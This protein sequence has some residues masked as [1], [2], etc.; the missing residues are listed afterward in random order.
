MRSCSSRE[1]I[2]NVQRRARNLLVMFSLALICT[3]NR[4]RSVMAH[5]ILVDE[6]QKR[7]L[8]VN[9]YSAGIFDFSDQ[10]Q[11]EETSMTCWQH[12]TSPPAEAPTFVRR[13]PLQSINRFLVM[14]QY[15]A[16]VLTGDYGV[17]PDRVRL[18]GSFDPKMRGQ[19]IADPFGRGKVEYERSY[20]LIRDCLIHYLETTDD[21]LHRQPIP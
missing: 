13:L 15:H 21:Q 4:C 17:P 6:A 3:A 20:R 12:H 5:A 18:L 9:V 11:L 7:A 19:E 10:P 16:E 8:S 14:E 1:N 2:Y